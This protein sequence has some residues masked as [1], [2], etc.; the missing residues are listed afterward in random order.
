MLTSAHNY[1]S[2]VYESY[3]EDDD[4]DEEYE[5]EEE[6]EDDEEEIALRGEYWFDESGNSMYADGDVGDMNHEMYVIQRC[7][8]EILGFYNVDLWDEYVAITDREEQLILDAILETEGLSEDSENEEDFQKVEN[9]K[10]D[11]QSY[12]V[13]DLVRSGHCDS[14]KDAEELV[15]VAYDS[16]VDARKYAIEKWGWSR[17][18]GTSIEVKRL[19]SETLSR[20]Y[21]GI[22]NAL[23]S[24]GSTHS[25]KLFESAMNTEYHIS[26]Y[27]GRH[28]T[29][30]LGDMKSSENVKNLEEVISS[31]KTAATKQLRD[32]DIGT[33]PDF[34]Q[35][36]GVIGDSSNITSFKQ[37]Y[38]I[39]SERA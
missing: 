18:H 9:I 8:S 33:M 23:D 34:Y 35:K 29:I 30:K 4:G 32:L 16:A 2:V 36:K 10:D 14:L 19:D 5:E 7:A 21:K 12:I 26:T 13:Q 20:V 38:K 31:P 6:E 39:F 3:H 15:K 17:V 1:K 25:D 37:F 11:I 28:Y 27:T 22:L 24:E